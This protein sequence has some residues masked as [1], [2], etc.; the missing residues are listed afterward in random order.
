MYPITCA[1]GYPIPIKA[2]R[3]L[4]IVALVVTASDTTAATRCT[5]VDDDSFKEVTDS[6]SLKTVIADLKG[7]ANAEGVLG[8]VFPE[9]IKVRKG[10]TISNGTNMLAGRTFVYVK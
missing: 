10:I 2:G 7:L 5:F 9:P 3:G 4:Q 6:Q 8:F 1:G